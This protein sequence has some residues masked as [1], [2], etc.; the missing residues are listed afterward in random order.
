M[1]S[2]SVASK[3]LRVYVSGLEST[4]AGI[5]IGVDSK[6]TYTALKLRRIEP[7]FCRR[8]DLR[9]NFAAKEVTRSKKKRHTSCRNG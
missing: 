8:A 4:L 3:G 1:F 6:A 2:V 7:F 9:A 5:S